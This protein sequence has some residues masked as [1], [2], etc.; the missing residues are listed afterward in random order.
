[1]FKRMAVILRRLVVEMHKEPIATIQLVTVFM[2]VLAF[3]ATVIGWINTPIRAEVDIPLLLVGVLVIL[4]IVIRTTQGFSLSVAILIVGTVVAGDRF[5]LAITALLRGDSVRTMEFVTDIYGASLSK[6]ADQPD[7]KE[8][9][10]TIVSLI[11][12]TKKPEKATQTVEKMIELA[13][14]ERLAN[15]VRENGAIPPLKNLKKGGHE[16]RNFVSRF[17]DKERFMKD[18]DDLKHLN[19]IEFSNKNY[20]LANITNLGKEVAE[21]L[22]RSQTTLRRHLL[23]HGPKIENIEDPSVKELVVDAPSTEGEFSD[24]ST[25]WFR[26]KIDKEAEYVIQTEPTMKMSFVDTA[27]TLYDADLSESLADNDDGDDS[28]SSLF[29]KIAIKLAPGVYGLEV[30]NLVRQKAKY[31]IHIRETKNSISPNGQDKKL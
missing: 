5:I 19:L 10:K 24:S 16:W 23:P 15:V 20:A 17:K 2:L 31:K 27:I 21:F 13:E 22:D 12:K 30:T 4:L 8:L 3:F 11:Q 9:A 26:I 14:V 1:M 6:T 25:N 7:R 18:M 28:D 29:S